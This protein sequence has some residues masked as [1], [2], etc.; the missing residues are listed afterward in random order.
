[1]DG[2]QG[3]NRLMMAVMGVVKERGGDDFLAGCPAVV[4]LYDMYARYAGEVVE[5]GRAE[6]IFLG[7]RHHPYT[8]GLFGS[9][10]G[11]NAS[12]KRLSPIDGL[13]PD[14]TALPEGCR[15]HPRCPY[16]TEDC[17]RAQPL[18]EIS[19]EHFISCNRA[20]EIYGQ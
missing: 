17:R 15:F 20:E 8:E 7:D 6:D 12:A 2:L 16:A 1:M 3:F 4:T 11:L 5:Y 18:R 13:M 19:P 10:P 9:L 14:P